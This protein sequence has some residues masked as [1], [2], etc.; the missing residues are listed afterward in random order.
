M[1]DN[2]DN[3]D[4]EIEA[5]MARAE[6]MIRRQRL[7]WGLGIAAALLLTAGLFF[8]LGYG[9]LYIRQGP[10]REVVVVVTATG[11]PIAATP[12]ATAARAATLPPKATANPSLGIGST[13]TRAKDGMVMVYV[14]AVTDYSMSSNY[15][16][17]LDAFWMDEHEVTNAMYK[18]CVE[19][20]GCES[21]SDLLYYNNQNY[22]VVYV[23]WNKANAYCAWADVRLPTEAEWEY[24]ARG[25]LNGQD[26]PWGDETPFCTPS[27]ENG[28]QYGLCFPNSPIGVKNFQ[29]NG[30]GLYDMAGNVREWVGDWY[31]N[32]PSGSFE[33]PTGP[34]GGKYR[35][36]RGG[37]WVDNVDDLRVSDRAGFNPDA[38]VDYIG[39]R[40]L[41]SP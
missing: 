24:A 28:A 38:T 5:G 37:S 9:L 16:V 31:G 30:Y 17:S 41:R 36:L 6:R 21:P 3:L 13:Q 14:P 18:K 1:T 33:N 25:G 22:P 32:Y 7:V 23:D 39:F 35:V 40:C 20:G 26:Y 19:A 29:P 2:F 10:A 4:K 11:L 12:A 27:A 15:Q 34:K 8:G